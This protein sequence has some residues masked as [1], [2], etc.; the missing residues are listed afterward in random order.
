MTISEFI[1]LTKCHVEDNYVVY[2]YDVNE[3]FLTLEQLKLDDSSNRNTIM[4]NLADQ[5]DTREVVTELDKAAMMLR[6][7]YNGLTT[8]QV[9]ILDIQ[10][11]EV[12]ALI[13]DAAKRKTLL[14]QCVI[15]SAEIANETCPAVIDYLTTMTRVGMEDDCYTYHYSIDEN[16]ADM[17]LIIQNQDA[18][19]ESLKTNILESTDAV[20]VNLVN[21]CKKV[22]FDIKYGIEGSNS[23]KQLIVRLDLMTGVPQ[24]TVK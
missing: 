6:Y 12:K 14:K 9:T 16:V 20:I 19:I 17:D 2:E 8:G 11:S 4:I 13:G 18:F 23:G 21:N 22:G 15:Q 10:P 5:S 1:T 24:V 7:K 3:D